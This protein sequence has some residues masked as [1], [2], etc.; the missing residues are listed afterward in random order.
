[1]LNV[2]KP[3]LSKSKDVHKVINAEEVPVQQVA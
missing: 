3:A 2:G 1:M